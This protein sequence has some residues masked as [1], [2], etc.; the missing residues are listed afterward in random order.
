MGKG[1]TTALVCSIIYPSLVLVSKTSSRER[2]VWYL[3]KRYR[4]KRKEVIADD[5]AVDPKAVGVR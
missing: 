5:N 2:R 4:T 3:P 1:L